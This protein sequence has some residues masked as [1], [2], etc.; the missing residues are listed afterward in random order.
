[1]YVE[2]GYRLPGQWIGKPEAFLQWSDARQT[3]NISLFVNSGS[4]VYAG[5]RWRW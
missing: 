1:M 2:L 4:S 5:T 3:S